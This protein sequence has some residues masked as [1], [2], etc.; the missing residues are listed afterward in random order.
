MKYIINYTQ[1]GKILGF[2]KGDTGLNIEVSNAIWFE[3]QG[4]NKIII[5]G[6]NISFDK[7]NW[8]SSQEIEKQE[9][10]LKI[11]EAKSYLQSTDYKM[12]VDYFATL[13]KDIQDELIL[14]RNEAREFIRANS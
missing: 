7:V 12:T 14:K 13:S 4:M 11:N 5:D 8:R 1:E 6:E 3:N 2:A 9:L 10:Q